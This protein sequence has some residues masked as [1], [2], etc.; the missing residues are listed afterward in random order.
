MNR[1]DLHDY[2][3]KAIDFIIK[4]NKCAVWLG[5]G[6]GKTT[7]T[8]T[9]LQDLNDMCD[10]TKTLIVA[11]LRVAN[12][13]WHHEI[14]NWEHINLTYSICTGTVKQR[15]DGLKKDADIYIINR[16]NI[17][18]LIDN[19]KWDFDMVVIDES[20]SFKSPSSKRFKKLKKMK[21]HRM[22]QLTGTPAPN[23]LLDLWSQMFLLDSG[24]RLGRSMTAYKSRWFDTDF[25]GYNVTPKSF[26]D[27]QIHKAISD[28]IL[29]LPLKVKTK[30]IDITRSAKFPLKL[31]KQYTEFE[32]EFITS[33]SNVD[34]TA[35]TAAT[36]SNKMLQFCSGQLYDE[37]KNIHQVHDLKLDILKEIMDEVD[38]PVL[39]AYNY[40]SEV[41]KILKAFP[42]AELLDKD[43]K[44]IE[45]WNNKEIPMLIAH[46]ASCGHGLNLQHG[47]SILVWYGVTW[48]LELYQQ[49]VA[50]L[51]RQGQKDTVRNIHIVIED[52]I[53]YRVMNALSN[54]A[55]TQKKLLDSVIKTS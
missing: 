41:E 17:P 45:R 43:V 42:Q 26:A 51:D 36:L 55:T 47:G 40:K 23:G 4:N 11:P 21:Y 32:N 7:S 13:V 8:L 52:T 5:M 16:E 24:A 53:E 54:K 48:S 29:N 49:L 10:I 39:I 6:G 14:A 44:T 25:M 1:S 35:M 33:I 37:D 19:Y 27:K 12:S 46:S 50:R 28:V 38:E 30:R 15:Q 9:A 18:W 22:I 3:L 20:S 31:M 34:I 2:Q